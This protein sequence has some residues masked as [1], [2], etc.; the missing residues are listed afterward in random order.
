[1]PPFGTKAD[2]GTGARPLTG[3]RDQV[4]R[5]RSRAAALVL[6]F[7]FCT[8]H[9]LLAVFNRQDAVSDAGAL[10]PVEADLRIPPDASAAEAI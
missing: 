10:Q 8:H 5:R 1:M 6:P 9:R 2:T 7:R 4:K 3:Q